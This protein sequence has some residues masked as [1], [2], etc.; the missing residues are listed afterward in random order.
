MNDGPLQ[1]IYG[2]LSDSA[3]LDTAVSKAILDQV[4]SGELPETLQVGLP[5]RI[6]AFG[7]HD[8]LAP[9]FDHAVQ[10]ATDRGFDT[11]VRIA[12]GRAVVFHKGI[13]RFAWT[14]PCQEP[15]IGMQ[16]R[17]ITVADRVVALLMSFGI[18]AA[19]GELSGEYCP[20]RYSV[21]INGGGKV[22]GSGQRMT[23]HAAQVGGMIVV[24]DSE[25]VND[26]LIPV[27]DALG[28]DMDPTRTGAIADV[29]NVDAD[30]VMESFALQFAT[31]PT[32]PLATVDA[33]TMSLA[34]TLQSQYDPRAFA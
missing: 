26:V 19:M 11:T 20:G 13:V 4:S 15:V 9:A 18:P 32:T 34:A 27:Y 17:F 21:H 25:T 8:T 14:V 30:T 1:I 5:H 29:V 23:Q 12:G 16:D 33:S 3:S 2:G 22:M 31:G 28:L 6:V 24:N 7:K 10:I